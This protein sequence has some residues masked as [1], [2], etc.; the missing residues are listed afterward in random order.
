MTDDTLMDLSDDA[1]SI[2]ANIEDLRA[3]L[4]GAGVMV[5]RS[6]EDHQVANKA[7]ARLRAAA[8]VM[9]EVGLLLDSIVASRELT[10]AI[11]DLNRVIAQDQIDNPRG[12]PC[13][14][15]GRYFDEHRPKRDGD[16]DMHCEGWR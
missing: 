16:G 2:K 1:V 10:T 9:E 5:N 14:D 13:R 8:A 15:C 7:R 12:H 4:N 11:S 3:R 6:A